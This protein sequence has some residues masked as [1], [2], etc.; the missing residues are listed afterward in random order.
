MAR[1][2][3]AP[4]RRASYSDKSTKSRLK[5]G[6]DCKMYWGATKPGCFWGFMAKAEASARVNS[7]RATKKIEFN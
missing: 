5:S 2:K 3:I 1:N 4:T 6:C 7:A